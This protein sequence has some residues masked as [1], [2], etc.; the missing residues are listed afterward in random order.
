MGGFDIAATMRFRDVELFLT[1]GMS[2]PAGDD[3]RIVLHKDLRFLS[4]LVA[5]FD[6]L[7]PK[8]MVEVGVLQGGSAIFWLERYGLERLVAIDL[9]PEIASLTNYLD[10]HGLH[11]HVRTRFGIAQDDRDTMRRAVREDLAGEMADAIIDDASHQLEP[12]RAAAEIL[13]PFLREGGVYVIEDW[14]WGHH[15][16]WPPELWT[17]N[18]LMSRLIIELLLVCGAGTGVLDR[19]EIDPNF[20]VLRRGAKALPTDGSFRM[21]DYYEPR[22]L[23]MAP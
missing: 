4:A 2:A 17:E 12:T 15:H 9:T 23:R 21:R 1:E 6:E 8:R 22:D 16:R 13:L 7:R 11:R 14:A 3:H 19:V 20:V 5:I 10:R 18:P